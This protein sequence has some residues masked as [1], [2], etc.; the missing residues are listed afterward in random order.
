M[1]GREERRATVVM[2]N[3]AFAKWVTVFAG[4]EKLTAALPIA[5]RIMH[6]SSPP[7]PKA[8]GSGRAGAT[9]RRHEPS[10][11]RADLDSLEH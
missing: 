2:T 4:N 11:H 7:K 9:S 5:S 10:W 3:L 8:I 1:T 6:R